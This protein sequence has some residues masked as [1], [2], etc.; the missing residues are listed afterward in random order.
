MTK[1]LTPRQEMLCLKYLEGG[2]LSR[3]AAA[4]GYSGRWPHVSGGKALKNPLVAARLRELQARATDETVMKVLERKHRLSEIARGQISDYL[5][6]AG[7]G[8]DMERIKLKPLPV[9]RIMTRS[10]SGA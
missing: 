10:R 7:E 2:N 6:D 8:I 9:Q 5:D 3:A 1:R 4:A